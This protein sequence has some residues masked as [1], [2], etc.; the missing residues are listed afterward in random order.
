MSL[1]LVT[2][3]TWPAHKLLSAAEPRTGIDFSRALSR[4]IGIDWQG[5]SLG[6]AVADLAQH[7]N[8][9]I[10]LDRR[11]DPHTPVNLKIQ[12]KPATQLL[13]RLATDL[14]LEIAVVESVIYIAPLGVGNALGSRTSQLSES[15][16]PAGWRQKIPLGWPRLSEPRA[17]LQ[18]M[19]RQ[20]QVSLAHLERVPHDLWDAIR[21]PPMPL[22]LQVEILLAGFDL[23][24]VFEI[25]SAT[26]SPTT[27]TASTYV[28][29]HS[30]PGGFAWNER[31]I[32]RVLGRVSSIKRV[33]R[34]AELQG[35]SWQ[36]AKLD[37]LLRVDPRQ[38]A[39]GTKR[40]TV[41][42]TRGRLGPVVKQISGLL[43]LEVRYSADV[44]DK[45]LEQI[46]EFTVKDATRVQLLDAILA[47]TSLRHQLVDNQWIIEPK[48]KR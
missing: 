21:L 33:G 19:V 22:F 3:A 14:Q 15:N 6:A 48:D 10:L 36:H 46:V 32:I 40:Y 30:V 8:I 34:R 47:G 12:G 23:R 7:L 44:T 38:I 42:R 9:V 18:Q 4:E 28:R 2:T 37:S 20:R 1:T 24:L 11:V 5:H 13:D 43:K 17:R 39:V 27:R 16:L 41:P 35:T 25:N 31:D 29:S 26:V 45:D